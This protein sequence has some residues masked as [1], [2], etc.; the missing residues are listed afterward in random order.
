MWQHQHRPRVLSAFAAV[1]VSQRSSAKSRSHL[2]ALRGRE[3]DVF[4]THRSLI[5]W[6]EGSAPPWV[7]GDRVALNAGHVG[8][9]SQLTRVASASKASEFAFER[10]CSKRPRL[11]LP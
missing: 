9:F 4:A 8:S 1:C 2:R 5:E 7:V 3:V 10:R 6:N 11:R